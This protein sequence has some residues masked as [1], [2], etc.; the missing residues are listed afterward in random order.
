MQHEKLNKV[1]VLKDFTVLSL[2]Q[3]CSVCCLYCTS[4]SR[5]S[6]HVY[7]AESQALHTMT[8]AMAGFLSVKLKSTTRCHIYTLPVLLHIHCTYTVY[9]VIVY[10]VTYCTIPQFPF[11]YLLLQLLYFSITGHLKCTNP[12]IQVV[13]Q[14]CLTLCS[15][16]KH[17]RR[18]KRHF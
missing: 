1:R 11:L 9:I 13:T 16:G 5:K 12:N 18:L 3:V 10:P 7:K 15:V 6:S 14:G 4:P 8:F 2:V 17:N